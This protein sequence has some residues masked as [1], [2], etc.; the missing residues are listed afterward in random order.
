MLVHTCT[1]V[2]RGWKRMLDPLEPE[3]HMVVRSLGGALVGAGNQT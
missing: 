1:Q 2:F 3:L